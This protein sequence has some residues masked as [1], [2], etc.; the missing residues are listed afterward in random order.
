MP[1]QLQRTCQPAP[2]PAH[3]IPR[4]LRFQTALPEFAERFHRFFIGT[5]C[6]SVPPLIAKTVPRLDVSYA[7]I[8]LLPAFPLQI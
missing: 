5:E 7:A 3:N 2:V 4:W 6:R 8:C 1:D